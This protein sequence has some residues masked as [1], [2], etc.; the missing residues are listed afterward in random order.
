MFSPEGKLRDGG[1]KFLKKVRS[2]VGYFFLGISICY[3]SITNNALNYGY[4]FYVV[5]SNLTILLHFSL[6]Y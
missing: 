3:W 5:G 2:G 4:C 6:G 1:A